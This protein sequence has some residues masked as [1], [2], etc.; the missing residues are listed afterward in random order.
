MTEEREARWAA[1][2]RAARRGDD[3]E[4]ARL[5]GEMAGVLRAFVRRRLSGLGLSPHDAEDVVQEAL[6]AIHAK[7]ATWDETRPILPWV[8]AIA[9]YKTLDA[10]RR[11]GRAR[12]LTVD[13]PAEDFAEIVAAPEGP[14]PG[15]EADAQR[16]LAALPDGQR[17]AVEAVALDGLSAAEAGE[18]LG[19]NAGAVRVA[20]HRGLKRLARLGGNDGDA[21]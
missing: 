1:A 13:A 9:R 19:M 5:L 10:A 3:A 11:R 4:Y 17:K 12:R 18:K 14:P 6:I 7:R 2:M 16:L 15:A 8:H 20:L 21:R